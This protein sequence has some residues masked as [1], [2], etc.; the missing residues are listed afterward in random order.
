[1]YPV[2]DCVGRVSP[3]FG[4]YPKTAHMALRQGQA[5]AAAIAAAA[6]GQPPPA[7]LPESVCH[8]FT[9]LDPAQAM[10]IEAGYRRRG[11]GLIAQTVRQVEERQ[12]RDEDLVWM[13]RM[14][15]EMDLGGQPDERTRAAMDRHGGLG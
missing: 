14:I 6:R 5:A 4:P 1:V 11:D 13:R 2:G 10:R 7:A 9:E 15:M 3:L 12:P 8:V